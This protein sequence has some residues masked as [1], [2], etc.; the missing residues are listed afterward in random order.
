MLTCLV[1]FANYFLSG[2]KKWSVVSDHYWYSLVWNLQFMLTIQSHL[3]NALFVQN[4]CPHIMALVASYWQRCGVA[5]FH[6]QVGQSV[7]PFFDISW[8]PYFSSYWL[9]TYGLVLKWPVVLLLFII[10]QNFNLRE[11]FCHF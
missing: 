2:K 6:A 4:W 7:S 9:A 11:Y 10:F 1:I 5:H 8:C 3:T